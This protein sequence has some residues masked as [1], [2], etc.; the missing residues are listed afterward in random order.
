MIENLP[1]YIPVV[2]GLTTVAT[3]IIFYLAIKLSAD[4]ETAGKANFVAIIL[5]F[6]LT[7]QAV[8]TVFGLYHAYLMSVPPKILLFG[9]LP[10]LLTIIFLFATPSGRKFIDNLS[11]KY[12]HWLH[13]VRLPVEFVLLWLFLYQAGPQ[14]MTFEGRNFDILSGITAPIVAYLGFTKQILN[15]NLILAWN[16]ICLGLL[17]N[18]VINGLLAAPTPM[19][20]FAFDRPN[21]AVF[22]FP[23]SWLPTFVVPVVL[24]C[25]LVAIRQLIIRV[26][27]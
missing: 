22:Y 23:F 4:E 6:W 8:V 12:I 20:Q 26:D 21:L 13:A 9:L 5:T 27:N 7:L 2:F 3:L 10:T 24:F 19:Q 25:H 11:L 14:L 18:V 16:F 1:T 17:L 15:K